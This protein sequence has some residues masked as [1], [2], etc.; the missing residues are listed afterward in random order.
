MLVFPPLMH[1]PCRDPPGPIAMWF[2]RRRGTAPKDTCLIVYER[3]DKN[4]PVQFRTY[5]NGEYDTTFVTLLELMN[6]VSDVKYEIP[7]IEIYFRSTRKFHLT[8][9]ES[10]KVQEELHWQFWRMECVHSKKGFSFYGV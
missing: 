3:P 10:L 7:K 2:A 9:E 5:V 1:Y 4:K 6:F 8:L